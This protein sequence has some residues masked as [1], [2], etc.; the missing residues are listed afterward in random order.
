MAL[1]LTKPGFAERGISAQ[2]TASSQFRWCQEQAAAGRDQA[3]DLDPDFGLK[4]VN[5]SLNLA[6][7]FSS[8]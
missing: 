6:A 7:Q 5:P 3:N 8:G 2:S 4:R 1:C